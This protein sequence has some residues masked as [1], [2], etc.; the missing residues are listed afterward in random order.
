MIIVTT[1]D[2][3]RDLLRPFGAEVFLRMMVIVSEDVIFPGVPDREGSFARV[4][5]FNDLA[6]V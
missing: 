3:C 1:D 6:A 4:G 5:R 2:C